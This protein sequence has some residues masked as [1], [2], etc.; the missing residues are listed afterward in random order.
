MPRKIG[1]SYTP[2]IFYRR[3]LPAS[4]RLSAV[5]RVGVIASSILAIIGFT[6]APLKPPIH[7]ALTGLAGLLAFPLSVYIVFV[8][9]LRGGG[10]RKGFR[11][12][13]PVTATA[14]SILAILAALAGSGTWRLLAAASL[15][16]LSLHVYLETG[17]WRRR[18]PK[19]PLLYPPLAGIAALA[20]EGPFTQHMLAL[21]LHYATGMI[22]VVSPMTF[23]RN[24]GIDPSR[25]ST[26][27]PLTINSLSL[28]VYLLSGL[29]WGY[30]LL[31]LS[32]I[33]IYF[34]SIKVW[35][36]LPLAVKGVGKGDARGWALAYGAV[37][38][39]A[40]LAAMLLAFTAYLAGKL[41]SLNLLHMVAMG[42][43]GVH[44]YMYTPFMLPSI[45]R[46]RVAPTMI[47][48]PP[49]GMAAASLLR[50]WA[51]LPSYTLLLISTLAL[52]A[53]FTPL[54]RKS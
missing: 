22:M 46:V 8:G 23:A 41:D 31:A 37:S 24:Y 39:L 38:H 17:A 19:L 50:P 7:M 18:E 35:K 10:P 49:L 26:Y 6:I 52:I 42:F 1:R 40:S 11:A 21:A 12:I 29:G 44:I 16:A 48:I 20:P 13:P 5:S 54:A 45:L 9:S 2:T 14:L 47:P 4:I 34:Y 30:G 28:G 53:L 51:P 36:A 32:S 15:I 33:L 27:I 3:G 25:P 43:V